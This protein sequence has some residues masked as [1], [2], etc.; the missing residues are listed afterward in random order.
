MNE[1]ERS[2]LRWGSL[3]GIFSGIIFIFVPITLFGFVPSASS[4][5]IDLVARF[6]Y[7]R[8][9]IAAGARDH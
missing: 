7:E 5:L 9:A 4:D 3:A 8:T 6:P 2:V 1:E